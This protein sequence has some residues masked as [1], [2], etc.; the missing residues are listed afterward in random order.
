G[1]SRATGS[2]RASGSSRGGVRNATPPGNRRSAHAQAELRQAV[3]GRGHEFVGVVL[4]GLGVLLG[5]AVYFDLAGPLGRGTEAF[6][7]W[8][9]GLDRFGLPVAL[10]SAVDAPVKKGQSSSPMRHVIR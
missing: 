8:I 9:L 10:L 4:L 6:V 3:Q 1:S 5:L 2:S 7:G